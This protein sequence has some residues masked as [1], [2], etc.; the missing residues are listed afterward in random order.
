MS[1]RYII[2][3]ACETVRMPDRFKDPI[4]TGI[5][6]DQAMQDTIEGMDGGDKVWLELKAGLKGTVSA[7]LS[8]GGL[9]GSDEDEED[10]GGIGGSVSGSVAHNL[11]LKN[12]GNDSLT[13][14]AQQSVSVT[15]GPFTG[16][17]KWM[18][19]GSTL[20]ILN[21][22]TSIPILKKG[23]A[24]ASVLAILSNQSLTKLQLKGSVSQELTLD[25]LKDMMFGDNGWI[26]SIKDAVVKGILTVNGQMDNPL[27]GRLA[28]EL[29]GTAT[30]SATKTL[31]SAGEQIAN[32]G[33]GGFSL[34]GGVKVSLGVELTWQKGQGIELQ[35]PNMHQQF[36]LDWIRREQSIHHQE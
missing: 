27:L 8:S 9:F 16:T 19:D 28:G 23:S 26:S 34:D 31:S 35:G 5:M 7:E 25:M 11:I 29:S 13:T 22:K 10:G 32:A 4:V 15:V 21:A 1:L 30:D 18:E 36:Y 24:D 17:R 2:E 3:S 12:D 14:E 33:G 6:S 20:D